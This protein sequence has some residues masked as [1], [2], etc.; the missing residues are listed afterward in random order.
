MQL[1][2]PFDGSPCSER[3]LQMGAR[4]VAG[5]GVDLTVVYLDPDD[6]DASDIA[7]R[8]SAVTDAASL[9]VVPAEPGSETADETGVAAGILSVVDDRGV[10]HVIIGHHGSGGDGL[11]RTTEHVLAAAPVPVTVVP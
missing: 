7:A 3:A 5:A 8:A 1:M 9:E 10:D 11:G 6:G 4:M 2:V